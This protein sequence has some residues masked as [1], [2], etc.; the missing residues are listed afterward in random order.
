MKPKLNILF[1]NIGKTFTQ[2]KLDL[3]SEAIKNEKPDVFCI[4][5]GGKKN[6][7]IKIVDE[8]NNNNYHCYYS[9]LLST[10]KKL[11]LGYRFQQLGLKIFVRDKKIIKDDFL[12]EA[13]REKGRIVIL[14]ISYNYQS[15]NIIFLHNK[16]KS[17]SNSETLEQISF[18]SNLKDMLDIGEIIKKDE[19]VIIIGDFNLEPWDRVLKHKKF[20][21]TSFFSNNNSI[22][23]RKNNSRHFYNP[24]VKYIS[25][26]SIINLGGSYY[27]SRYNWAL[28]DYVLYETKDVDLEFSI[29]EKFKNGT[30]LLKKDDRIKSS[31]INHKLDHL[32]IFIK[33]I[34]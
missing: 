31:F 27:G 22:K 11:K 14:K 15:L 8:F 13:Q 30:S 6:D 24:I 28:F 25:N 10:D 9:P 29:K 7:I 20:I 26:S 12:Y 5:E 16:S 33:V 1:W 21:N 2:K 34:K 32:P 4:A 17:G 23:T 18:I 3:I 19:R